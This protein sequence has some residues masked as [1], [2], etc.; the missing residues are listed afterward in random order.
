VRTRRWNGQLSS[1]K[2]YRPDADFYQQ[3]NGGESSSSDYHSDD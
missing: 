2:R 1:G 3:L